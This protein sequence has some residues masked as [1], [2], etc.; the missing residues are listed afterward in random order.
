MIGGADDEGFVKAGQPLLRT[1]GADVGAI[2]YFVFG[3][4][5]PSRL[6]AEVERRLLDRHESWDEVYKQ[7]KDEISLEMLNALRAAFETRSS[8]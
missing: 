6:A 8:A 7:Y 4:D 1:F 5:E 3:E 2:S